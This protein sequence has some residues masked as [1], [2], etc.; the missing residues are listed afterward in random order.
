MEEMHGQKV[1]INLD[2]Y[3]ADCVKNDINKDFSILINIHEKR[4]Y[5][6][7]LMNWLD[8]RGYKWHSGESV[9][10]RVYYNVVA[11]I[12]HPKNGYITWLSL[13]DEDNIDT[14]YILDYEDINFEIMEDESNENIETVAVDSNS[15]Q[16][17]QSIVY[18]SGAISG[19]TDYL[20]RFE[21]AET[22]LKSKGYTVINPARI[23]S[24]LPITTSWEQ[25]MEIDYKILDICDTI[26]MLDGWENSRG[27]KAEYDYAIEHHMNIMY[28]TYNKELWIA[29]TMNCEDVELGFDIC[30]NE[31]YLGN[32][33]FSVEDA[34][35]MYHWLGEKLY[36]N[37]VKEDS[38]KYDF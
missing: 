30:E 17:R 21:K 27:A 12:I 4:K 8:V 33:Y 15:T 37:T 31:Y 18:I 6:Y 9:I 32:R 35:R 38:I 25:Y 14:D 36:G 34:E 26:Y 24:F 28:Q 23:N 3:I 20:E 2:K 29:D 7:D 10:N 13:S 5:Y 11:I 19:T 1:L 16:Q 22:E